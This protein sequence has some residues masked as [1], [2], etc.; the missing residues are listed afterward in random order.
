MVPGQLLSR[1]LDSELL[2][3]LN[4]P[5]SLLPDSARIIRSQ[6]LSFLT[7]W[8]S[9]VQQD[10]HTGCLLHMGHIGPQVW[11]QNVSLEETLHKS[12]KRQF[13]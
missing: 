3:Q 4:P 13:R 10:T 8:Y 6:L 12:Q 9:P 5:C 11:T 7:A 2:P 1:L